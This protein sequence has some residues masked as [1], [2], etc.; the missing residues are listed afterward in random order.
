MTFTRRCPSDVRPGVARPCPGL[1][2]LLL[3]REAAGA[4]HAPVAASTPGNI[5][6]LPSRQ[7]IL[8]RAIARR[9]NGPVLRE[10]AWLQ[11][12][13]LGRRSTCR[14]RRANLR[15]PATTL[16]GIRQGDSPRL[17]LSP[18]TLPPTWNSAR[19]KLNS[20]SRTRA[21]CG[22]PRTGL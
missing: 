14:L 21:R 19:R 6:L 13:R 18:R 20:H 16:P 10:Q 1:L 15:R 5:V 3:A 22:G 4:L 2:T 9:Q 7:C 11:A 8:S 12:P 17:F